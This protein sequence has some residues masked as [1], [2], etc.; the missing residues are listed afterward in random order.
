MYELIKDIPYDPSAGP[1]ATGDLFL[2]DCAGAAKV[3]LLI[4]GGGWNAM[5]RHR[6][7]G[8]AEGL[9]QLGY[10]VFNIDYRLLPEAPYPACEQDCLAAGRFLLNSALPVVAGLNREAITVMGASAGGHLASAAAT[11][12]YLRR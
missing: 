11:R 1:T 7:D 6:M 12:F 9:V 8:I 10:A 3:M 5:N 4:H 2:P